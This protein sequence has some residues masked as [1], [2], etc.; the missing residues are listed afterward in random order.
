MLYFIFINFFFPQY[1]HVI[2]YSFFS[3]NYVLRYFLFFY[4]V[5]FCSSFGN[6]KA[7]FVIFYPGIGVQQ[8]GVM[9]E[10]LWNGGSGAQSTDQASLVV[11][12]RGYCFVCVCF[13]F[14]FF[15][16]FSFFFLNAAC[17]LLEGYYRCSYIF[18][19]FVNI[20]GGCTCVL[21]LLPTLFPISTTFRY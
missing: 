7:L 1:P 4:Y 18:S 16:L 2:S 8:T 17:P 11:M 21:V 6:R 20:D 13:C 5:P 14:A 10:V 12:R 15:S 3:C 19:L 9:P